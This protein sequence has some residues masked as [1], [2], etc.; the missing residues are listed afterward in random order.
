MHHGAAHRHPT[1]SSPA[2]GTTLPGTGMTAAFVALAVLSA[3][4]LAVVLLLPEDNLLIQPSRLALTL[5]KRQPSSSRPQKAT[6]AQV[7]RCAWWIPASIQHRDMNHLTL[8][9]WLDVVD[10]GTAAY[11]D[12][13]AWYIDGRSSRRSRWFDRIGTGCEPPRGERFELDREGDDQDLSDAIDWCI[14]R[15][16][17]S[18]RCR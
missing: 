15:V 9:G 10:N 17:T 7:S 13:R 1:G 8:A 3:G 2:G 6:R 11:D 14:D 18:F 4:V 16:H 5:K 12:Q